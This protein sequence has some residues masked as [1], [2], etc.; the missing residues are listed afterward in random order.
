MEKNYF[1]LRPKPNNINR[2]KEFLEKNII[3]VGWSDSGDL[4]GVDLKKIHLS[5]SYRSLNIFINEMK[6][7]DIVII[8]NGEKIYFAKIISEY[9]YDNSLALEEDYSNQRKV[10]FIDE[11]DRKSMP[12]EMKNIL[13][14]RHISVKLNKY[15]ELI[16]RIL[17]NEYVEKLENSEKIFTEIPIPIRNDV[18]AIIKIPKDFTK[19][20]AEKL[21]NIVKNLYFIN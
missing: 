20:E 14:T 13:K 1:L 6:I 8:P 3:A 9:F 16:E 5:V 4:T 12:L 19:E 21:G 18:N 17:N 10:K 11:R 7:G 2:I 15:G